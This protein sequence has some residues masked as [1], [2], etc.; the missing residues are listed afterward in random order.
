MLPTKKKN[1]CITEGFLLIPAARNLNFSLQAKAT[2]RKLIPGFFTVAMA[3]KSLT[4]GKWILNEITEGN[5]E[6]F[7]RNWINSGTSEQNFEICPSPLCWGLPRCLIVCAQ[8]ETELHCLYLCWLICF[9]LWGSNA[10]EVSQLAFCLETNDL[11]SET[12]Q[13]C[14]L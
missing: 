3:T 13:P 14:G 12:G 11:S 6:R 9:L 5:R 10:F 1:L 2:K 4:L 7:P 8:R